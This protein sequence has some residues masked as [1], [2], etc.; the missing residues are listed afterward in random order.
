LS[1]GHQKKSRIKA[2]NRGDL[3]I[4]LSNVREIQV[5]GDG[6]FG[7]VKLMED[8][9]GERYAVK[10]FERPWDRT[11]GKAA[12]TFSREFAGGLRTESS[13]RRPILWILSCNSKKSNSIGYEIYEELLTDGCS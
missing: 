13:L 1:D 5:L 11:K 8:E 4:D 7:V 12:T 2:T 3:P 6:I 9:D 10:H